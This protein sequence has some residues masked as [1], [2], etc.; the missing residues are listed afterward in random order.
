[1]K[2][3]NDISMAVAKVLEVLHWLAAVSMAGLLVCSFTARDWLA[4]FLSLA[5]SEGGPE[6][7]TYSFQVVPASGGRLDMTAVALFAV[8]SVIIL[9]LM[10]M[11]FRNAWL[12]LKKSRSSTPFQKDNVRMLR[13]IGIF[14][15]SAPLVGIGMAVVI[16]L[17]AGEGVETSVR[18]DTM[19]LGLLVFALS[20]IF[21]YGMELQKDVDGLL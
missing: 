21:T 19:A 9:S 1:M 8:G 4:G 14:A 11:V 2:R 13:E 5:L 10:A 17:A 12:I 7:A 6:L 20:N 18:F 3:F 15:A 16:R